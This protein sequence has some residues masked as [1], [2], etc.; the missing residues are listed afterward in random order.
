MPSWL[1]N[2]LLHVQNINLERCAFIP[3]F[4]CV[5][6][7]ATCAVKRH[8][9]HSTEPDV[10]M[11]SRNGDL[12]KPRPLSRLGQGH[13]LCTRRLTGSIPR[14][15]AALAT[16]AVGD[17]FW[18]GKTSPCR[19]AAAEAAVSTKSI[20]LLTAQH[21]PLWRKSSSMRAANHVKIKSCTRIERHAH[22]ARRSSGLDVSPSAVVVLKVSFSLFPS[23]PPET[24]LPSG[25]APGRANNA[26]MCMSR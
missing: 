20:A 3:A 25:Y 14:Q 4:P 6:T 16:L 17:H 22:Y 1:S 21:G 8:Q 18:P 2:G 9:P 12:I 10:L 15:G 5:P 11:R 13:K 24:R 19:E 23:C 7:L 26:C